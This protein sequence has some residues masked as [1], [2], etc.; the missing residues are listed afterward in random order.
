M[1]FLGV[2]LLIELLLS[3]TEPAQRQNRQNIHT[4]ESG[5]FSWKKVFWV[6]IQNV[7]KNRDATKP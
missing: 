3:A 1:F 2:F 4:A 5:N 7:R 6:F